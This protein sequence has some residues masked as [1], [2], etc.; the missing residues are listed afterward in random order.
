MTA[1]T[2]CQ[3]CQSIPLHSLPRP[4]EQLHLY[5]DDKPGED[6]TGLLNLSHRHHPSFSS[7]RVSAAVCLLC[8]QIEAEVDFTIANY[9]KTVDGYEKFWNPNFDLW[10]TGRGEGGDG[11]WV[12]STNAS[13]DRRELVCFAAFGYCVE[14]SK[15]GCLGGVSIVKRRS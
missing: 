13:D 8:R 1:A 9:V 5:S 15:L 7:L 4:S 11:F 3:L 10:I 6:L 2:L 14:D 12:C